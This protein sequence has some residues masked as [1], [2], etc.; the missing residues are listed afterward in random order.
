MLTLRNTLLP[1]L[2]IDF[3]KF[4]CLLNVRQ[5]QCYW[6]YFRSQLV[7]NFWNV[8]ETMNERVMNPKC[9]VCSLI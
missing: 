5:A 2:R 9:R 8:I 3:L 7:N 4:T 1:Y 6:Y